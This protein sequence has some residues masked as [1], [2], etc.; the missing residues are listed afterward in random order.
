MTNIR[1]M[2]V[3]NAYK[4]EDHALLVFCLSGKAELNAVRQFSHSV[5]P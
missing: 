1:K 5:W 2:A 4:K 3:M